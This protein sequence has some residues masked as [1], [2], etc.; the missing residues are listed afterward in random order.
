MHKNVKRLYAKMGNTL[1]F[2]I[3]DYKDWNCTYNHNDVIVMFARK[4]NGTH[5]VLGFKILLAITINFHSRLFPIFTFLRSSP[6]QHIQIICQHNLD[7]LHVFYVKEFA[8]MLLKVNLIF[9]LCITWNKLNYYK[10]AILAPGQK[11][12]GYKVQQVSI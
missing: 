9:I 7:S 11:L 5:I 8:T 1:Y 6:P 12:Q 10:I 3:K 4:K 2:C